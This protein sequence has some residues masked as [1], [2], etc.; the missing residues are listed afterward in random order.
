[1]FLLRDC[2]FVFDFTWGHW[3]FGI[4]GHGSQFMSTQK[5]CKRR[6]KT[7]VDTLPVCITFNS[8]SPGV[9]M[10]ILGIN[11]TNALSL[12]AVCQRC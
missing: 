2:P 1:M 4:S 10:M 9:S 5:L 3:H 11:G 6:R 8:S 12:A 7:F